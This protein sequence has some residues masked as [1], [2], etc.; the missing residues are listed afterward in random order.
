FH[1]HIKSKNVR[2]EAWLNPSVA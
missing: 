2:F 1:F